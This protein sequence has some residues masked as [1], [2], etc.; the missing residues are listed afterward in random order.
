M[1]QRITLLGKALKPAEP[2]SECYNFYFVLP[3]D[4]TRG[5][6]AQLAEQLTLNQ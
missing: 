4:P 3:A 2:A 1:A 5:R 6:V